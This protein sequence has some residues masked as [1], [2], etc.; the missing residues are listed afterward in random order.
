MTKF[1]TS[2]ACFFVTQT[3]LRT[4]TRRPVDDYRKT[5]YLITICTSKIEITKLHF[6]MHSQ[7]HSATVNVPDVN[8]LQA[9]GKKEIP[10]TDNWLTGIRWKADQRQETTPGNCSSPATLHIRSLPTYLSHRLPTSSAFQRDFDLSFLTRC[11]R[12]TRDC[13]LHHYF[14]LKC[15]AHKAFQR[16]D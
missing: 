3:M 6:K 2:F 11:A 16:C 15:F 13:S 8:F 4:G 10:A 7:R 14:I 1:N 9:T 5:F 12:L